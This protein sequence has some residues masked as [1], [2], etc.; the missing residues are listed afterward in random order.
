M[1]INPYQAFAPIVAINLNV[2]RWT[3]VQ[4]TWS[5]PITQRFS[6]LSIPITFQVVV[7]GG[8]LNMVSSSTT[9]KMFPSEP[10]SVKQLNYF[11]VQ[12]VRLP[13]CAKQHRTLS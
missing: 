7:G 10:K 12:F 6:V 11:Q 5:S 4:T 2:D 8:V 13:L 9:H 3:E 1:Q